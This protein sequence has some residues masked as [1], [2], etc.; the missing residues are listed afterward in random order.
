MCFCCGVLEV[1]AE[2]TLA[3]VAARYALGACFVG[4]G[5][6]LLL[7]L[8]P[9]CVLC[10]MLLVR[11]KCLLLVAVGTAGSLGFRCC[12]LAIVAGRCLLGAEGPL[13]TCWPART[14]VAMHH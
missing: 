6:G 4:V 8:G 5:A 3:A 7:F 12:C 1:A 10:L 14:S 2:G 13:M 11:G 9:G